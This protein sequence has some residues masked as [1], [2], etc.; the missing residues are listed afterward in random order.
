MKK[1]KLRKLKRF[2]EFIK[3]RPITDKGYNWSPPFNMNSP[4]PNAS[5]VSISSTVD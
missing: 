2:K 3:N 1:K 4:A 5:N